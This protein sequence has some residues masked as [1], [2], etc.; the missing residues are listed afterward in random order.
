M[1][2]NDLASMTYQIIDFFYKNRAKFNSDAYRLY[3]ILQIFKLYA[4]AEL[5]TNLNKDNIIESKE[6]QKIKE[7]FES[8]MQR[9]RGLF[10]IDHIHLSSNLVYSRFKVIN[11][12][13]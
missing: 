1:D 4:W 9:H 5:R 12:N 11:N 2:R 10:V 13:I 7:F 6:L 8:F 3:V